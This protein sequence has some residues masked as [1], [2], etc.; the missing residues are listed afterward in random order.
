MLIPFQPKNK[1][2]SKI[3]DDQKSINEREFQKQRKSY[4]GKNITGQSPADLNLNKDRKGNKILDELNS[5]VK[6][7]YK[8]DYENLIKKYYEA[9]QNEKIRN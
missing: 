3:L 4:N 1:I 8:K 9:L 6:E 2:L 5:A 7:G